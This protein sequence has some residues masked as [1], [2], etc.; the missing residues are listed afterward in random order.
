MDVG[1]ELIEAMEFGLIGVL[2]A[3]SFY[4]HLSRL[5]IYSGYEIRFGDDAV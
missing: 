5:L 4:D 2:I 3:S 1:V